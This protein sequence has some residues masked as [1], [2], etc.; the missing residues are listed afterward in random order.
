MNGMLAHLPQLVSFLISSLSDRKALV[1]S[2][3]CW[4]LSRYSHW[5]VSQPHDQFLKRLMS[6]VKLRRLFQH[7]NETAHRE[8]KKMREGC[9]WRDGELAQI[10]FLFA[11]ISITELDICPEKWTGR[12]FFQPMNLCFSPRK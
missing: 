1:R 11:L 8:R 10:F 12:F 4:T 2:I 7:V 3:T 5:I 6:E 9:V